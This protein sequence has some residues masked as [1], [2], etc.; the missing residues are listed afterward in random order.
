MKE[1]TMKNGR[2][3][4]VA[5]TGRTS[6]KKPS[7][8]N[9]PKKVNTT[10]KA[11]DAGTQKF[12]KKPEK[13]KAGI[14]RKITSK[15]TAPATKLVKTKAKSKGKD[16]PTEANPIFIRVSE[17]TRFMVYTSPEGVH[18]AKQYSTKKAPDE[19]K[20]AK[21]GFAL[22]SQSAVRELIAALQKSSE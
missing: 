10:T 16:K 13:P 4:S 17:H 14:K 19:W 1:M 8:S 6:A 12:A 18:C 11:D 15:A 20:F 2:I 9:K 21:G 22:T 3:V 5:K 7:V